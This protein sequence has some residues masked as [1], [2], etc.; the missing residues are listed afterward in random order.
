MVFTV[1]I[2]I[3]KNENQELLISLITITYSFPCDISEKAI[4]IGCILLY[5]PD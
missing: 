2:S 3:S 1:Y 5:L 4:A